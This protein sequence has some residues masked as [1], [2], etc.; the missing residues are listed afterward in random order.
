[1]CCAYLTYQE[2][3]K[4]APAACCAIKA[5]ERLNTLNADPEVVASAERCRKLQECH[6]TYRRAE[7]LIAVRPERAAELFREVLDKAPPDTEIHVAAR[8]QLAALD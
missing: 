5:N 1:M 4:L 6:H 3:S 7:R 8:K 2:A